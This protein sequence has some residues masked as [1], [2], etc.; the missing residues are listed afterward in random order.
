MTT[1]ELLLACNAGH[2]V[3]RLITMATKLYPQTDNQSTFIIYKEQV[4]TQHSNKQLLLG[5]RR[6]KIQIFK[7][8]PLRQINKGSRKL[9]STAKHITVS[10]KI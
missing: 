2:N 5:L 9:D 4:M 7:I 10:T 8:I 6:T 1:K 3:I